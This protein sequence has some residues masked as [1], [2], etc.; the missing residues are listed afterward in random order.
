MSNVI[1]NSA[2]QSA[3]TKINQ[4]ASLQKDDASLKTSVGHHQPK[5]K[6]LKKMKKKDD[7]EISE[8]EK[9]HMKVYYV[10]YPEYEK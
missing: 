8:H 6:K 4:V 2:P 3:K 9:E 7:E 5:A 10:V 1:K